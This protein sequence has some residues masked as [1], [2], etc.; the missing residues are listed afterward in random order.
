MQSA[1][2]ILN[3]PIAAL[4]LPADMVDSLRKLGLDRVC[5]LAA[6][7]RAPLALR[8][9]P[10]L[11]RRLDQ[12]MGRLSEPIEP[13]RPPEIVEVRRAFGEPIGAAETIARYTGKLVGELCAVLENCAAVVR[14]QGLRSSEITPYQLG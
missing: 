7:P 2:A 12:A 8:F 1:A 14:A 6:K 4:R 3:L 13:I 10:E 11:G 9:G 5:D